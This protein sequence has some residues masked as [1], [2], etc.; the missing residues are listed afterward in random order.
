MTIRTHY[1]LEC[2]DPD[3]TNAYPASI[4][5]ITPAKIR[6]EAAAD[7]WDIRRDG[8]YCAD[9]HSLPPEYRRPRG[10]C[11]ACNRELPLTAG[12]VLWNHRQRRDS[13]ERWAAHCAGS[14][15]APKRGAA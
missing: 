7:G 3:C 10:I 6:A 13:H 5:A 15:Q 12:G 1:A 4:V 8:D 11:P 14:R 2:S 9:G